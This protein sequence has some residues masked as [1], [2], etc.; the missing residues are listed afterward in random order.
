MSTHP[1]GATG[2]AGGS[3][4]K[5]IGQVVGCFAVGCFA[6]ALASFFPRLIAVLGGDPTR[7]VVL[8]STDYLLVGGIVATIVGLVIV[9][10]E[11]GP[12]R[13]LRDVFM[14]A[15]GVP[16]L[17]LGGLSATAT[18][19]NIAQLDA[20]LTATTQVLQTQAD[21]PTRDDVSV[22]QLGPTSHW[23]PLDLLLSPALAQSAAGDVRTQ[24]SQNSLGIAA[25]QNQYYVVFDSAASAELLKTRQAQIARGGVQSAVVRGSKGDFLLVPAD[26]AVKQ[27]SDAV[28]VASRAKQAGAPAFIVPVQPR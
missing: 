28:L 10:I 1:V 23:H 7:S 4:R 5:T 13:Q 21:V 27:Y 9:I 3:H 18:S 17:L 2:T 22:P 25:R 26:G 11:G 24:V 14:T 20:R 19:S 6:G 16:T 15:L 8:F 12:G